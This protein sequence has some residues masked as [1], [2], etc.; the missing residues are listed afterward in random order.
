MK[1]F[2]VSQ[3]LLVLLIALLPIIFYGCPTPIVVDTDSKWLVLV[4]LDGDN[5]LEGAAIDDF[6]EMENALYNLGD[7]DINILALFDRTRGYDSSNDDWSET[8]LYQ[9]MPDN[10]SSNINSVLLKNYG[11]LNMGNPVTLSNFISYAKNNYTYE[12]LMLIFWNHGGGARSKDITDTTSGSLTKAVCWDDTDGEDCLYLD[13]VQQ[14]LTYK[15]DSS[16]KLDIL[17]FDACLMGTVEVAYEFADVAS[18]MVASMHTEQGDGWDYEKI[19]YGDSANCPVLT[20]ADY[21]TITPSEFSVRIVKSYRDFI[22]ETYTN[23]AETMSAIDLTKVGAIKLNLDTLA[24]NLKNYKAAFEGFRDNAIHFWTDDSDS[25]S[26]PYFDIY[27]LMLKIELSIPALSAY[28]DAVIASLK[29]AVLYAYG[30]DGST[31]G[32]VQGYYFGTGTDVGHGLSIFVSRGEKSYEGY[33]HYAYQ[34]WYTYLDTNEWW[35]GGHF[36]GFIDFA[37]SDDNGVV[38]YW[39]ELFEYWYDPLNEATPGTW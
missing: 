37:Q 1:K 3:F 19:F 16:N 33:S 13:E 9:V 34:W 24:V 21:E 32:V 20:S 22:E 30:D 11:E 10:N 27:D 25:I 26:Y 8:R 18:Y 36:Y 5:N 39:R 4:Y 29:D 28:C 7:A 6:N 14:A 38:Q 31:G 23:T 35:S 2:K 15:F 17:G 12:N